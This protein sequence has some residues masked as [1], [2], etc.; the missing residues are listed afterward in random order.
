MSQRTGGKRDLIKAQAL[1]LFA[2]RGVD[3]VSVQ[4]IA[5]A[6]DMAKPNLY[7]HFASKD[8]LVALLFTEGYRDYGRMMAEAAA[9]H[10]PFPQKLATLVRLVCH[11]HDTDH[12]RFR[13]I[14]MAQH[15]NLPAIAIDAANPV[16][17]VVRLVEAAMERGEIATANPELLAAAIIGI[18]IQ[19]ATFMLYGRIGGSLTDHAASLT[20]ICLRAIT[21]E[22]GARHRGLRGA[23]A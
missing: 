3:A 17:I 4:G 15:A 14:L 22:A 9:T 1:R 18:V 5:A 16:E 8:A 19:P 10:G 12:L 20:E 13:F 7:A 2:E 21:P 23:A 6:C 11:L